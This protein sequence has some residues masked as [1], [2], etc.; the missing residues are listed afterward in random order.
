VLLGVVASDLH[1]A[2]HLPALLDGKLLN[3]I[4]L[5]SHKPVTEDYVPVLPWLGVMWWGMAGGQL[6]LSKG[7]IDQLAVSATLVPAVQLAWLGRWSLS[8]YMLHQPLLI[9]LLTAVSSLR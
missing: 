1:A 3:W 9:G 7:W 8:W 6:A 5:I 2:W 4:G